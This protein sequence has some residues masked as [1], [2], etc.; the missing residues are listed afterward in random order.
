MSKIK[1][2]K[3]EQIIRFVVFSVILVFGINH[4]FSYSDQLK[5]EKVLGNFYKL[6]D[7]TAD[8]I[9]IGSSITQRGWISPEAFNEKGITSYSL[10]TGSQPLVIAKYLMEESEKTQKPK[11]YIVE[12]RDVINGPD[13]ISE[14]AIRRITDNMK[15]SFNRINAVN[16]SLDFASKG[17]MEPAETDRISYYLK[18]MKYHSKWN[19]LHKLKTFD[20]KYYM[21]FAYY[22][23]TE[24]R[25]SPQPENE[26]TKG[27]R[28]I[29]KETEKILNGLLD[30]C[31]NLDASVMFV[32]APV[33][34]A[35]HEQE[36][37]NYAQKIIEKRGYE[38][39]N[40]QHSDFR[41]ELGVDSDTWFYNINHMNYYGAS[42]YTSFLS[43]Y[44]Y[45]RYNL[46]DRRKDKKYKEWENSLKAL[47]L[48]VG[49]QYRNMYKKIENA[50]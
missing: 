41:E 44:I 43:K 46:T 24:Y 1:K 8:V 23:K 25:I 37:V 15:F 26:E 13:E 49:N 2:I 50:L 42:K 39:L 5:S 33:G 38:V 22:E 12:L 45:S 18:F 7:N 4:S 20:I 27:V 48:Q 34:E 19:M 47:T 31:D 3:T 40:F 11:L 28:P 14:D 10:A 21:G 32:S 30:Y 17:R 29:N 35:R 36:K 6:E 9:Y 16:A